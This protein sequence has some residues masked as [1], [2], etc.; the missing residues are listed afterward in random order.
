[1][2][3]SEGVDLSRDS[4]RRPA[5]QVEPGLHVLSLLPTRNTITTV[6][7]YARG[8]SPESSVGEPPTSLHWMTKLPDS[9]ARL[10]VAAKLRWEAA[11]SSL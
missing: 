3:A 6:W 8:A 5:S 10:D 4:K 9:A 2:G 1:M 7:T 11:C